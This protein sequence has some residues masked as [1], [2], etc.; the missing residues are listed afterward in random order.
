MT[1]RSS[2]RWLVP[3][4]VQTSAMDCGPATLKCL[5][6]GFGIPVSYGRLREICHTSVDGTSIDT[7]EDLAN[8]L[9]LESEQW[10]LPPEHVLDS[11]LGT[12]PALVVTRLP[13]GLT[14]FVVAWRRTGSLVQVMD[15]GRG[16]QFV[17]ASSL[18]HDL[19]I[20]ESTLPEASVQDFVETTD[21]MEPLHRRCSALGLRNTNAL[22]ESAKA[23]GWRGLAC[24]DA[25]A[26]ATSALVRDGAIRLGQRLSAFTALYESAQAS[27]PHTLI[28]REQWSFLPAGTEGQ[29]LVRGAIVLKALGKIAPPSPTVS[30]QSTR[31]S[32]EGPG[33]L[34][35][36]KLLLK[37][38]KVGK[39]FPVVLGL[40]SVGLGTALEALLLRG[41]F[42]IGQR[43]ATFGQRLAAGLALTLLFL[44]FLFLDL[45]IARAL[46]SMGRGLELGLRRTFLRKLPRLGDAYFQSRPMSAMAEISHLLHWVRM[47]PTQ[48]G[49]LIRCSAELFATLA[50]LAW[51]HPPSAPLVAVCGLFMFGFPFLTQPFLLERDMR[52]RGHA[53]SLARFY[54]DALLGAQAIRAHTAEPAMV[55]EHAGRLREWARVAL[56]L[57]QTQVA[58]DLISGLVGFGFSAWLV[59][60]YLRTSAGTGWALLFVY[61]SFFLP[62][63]GQE[64]AFLVQQ[65]PQHRNITLRLLEPI[66]AKE[67]PSDDIPD[68][69][70]PNA[71]PLGADLR[72]SGVLV[73]VGGHP[74][75]RVE[76]L[77]LGTGEQ[78]AIVGASGAGKSSLVGLLLGFHEASQGEVL[79]DG[80]PLAGPCLGR[81]RRDTVWVDPT[82]QIWNTSLLENLRF[83]ADPDRVSESMEAAQ[84]E[85]ILG[86]LPMGLQTPLGASGAK[87][88]GGEGQRVRIARGLART[89]PRLV[90]LDEAF[91]G[92]ER[93]RRQSMLEAAR[94]RFAKAT[95]LCITHDIEETQ[96]F[97]RVIVLE[98]GRVVEDGPPSR[99][100]LQ[101]GSRYASLL[102]AE[103]RARDR[104]L[105]P[106]WRRLRVE[107]GKV[108][109]E[110]RK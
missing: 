9:G 100:L 36:F 23:K 93:P 4:V 98:S 24:L 94:H 12:L 103:T 52:M 64:L 81:L 38:Y 72:L 66:G 40:L 35:T 99:L 110:T 85:E 65:Y 17:R 44:A 57:C 61:W 74:I 104:L 31:A 79:V 29:V 90:I 18:E 47:L 26:R 75:L 7:L 11:R 1:C 78:V 70:S 76:D 55:S 92:L 109:E 80:S 84:I 32:Q 42:D 45:P 53:G 27:A 34:A 3:E 97:P 37:D 25:A 20:H 51:L 30:E 101:P 58:L 13:S 22:M 14:H 39:L 67:S 19:Y 68:G 50:G 91:C 77:H 73:E 107:D 54:L 83:G 33:P 89:P 46:A 28:P 95:L 105:G 69:D 6:A 15:P 16:R 43:L 21:F 49:Q 56:A 88:S 86:R 96:A 2:R 5:L 60:D 108:T 48:A 10:L 106:A 102:Q 41:A 87:L 82:V 62:L 71:N 63:L 8:E 59:A